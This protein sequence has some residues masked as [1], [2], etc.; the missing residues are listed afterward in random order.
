MKKV[1]ELIKPYIT[2]IFGA[3]LLL[4]YLN[5][6][7]FKEMALAIGIIAVVIASF[8]LVGGILFV[9]MG[10]KMNDTL[11]KYLILA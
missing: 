11:K 7:S 9:V 10:D 3:L 4:I 6:L 5:Y 1:S 8:S 2:I